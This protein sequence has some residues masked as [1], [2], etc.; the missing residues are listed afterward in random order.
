MS[1][2]AHKIALDIETDVDRLKQN[3]A[4]IGEIAAAT[5]TIEEAIKNQINGDYLKQQF[6]NQIESLRLDIPQLSQAVIA[7]GQENCPPGW[8]PYEQAKS[9][10]G[11][12]MR[13]YIAF[14]A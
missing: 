13:H 5:T 14:G 9:L 6:G 4:K 8:A 7:F 11:N 12:I 1:D 10:S 3:I 2:N